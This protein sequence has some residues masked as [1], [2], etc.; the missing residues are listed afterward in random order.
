MNK[1]FKVLSD[2]AKEMGVAFSGFLFLIFATLLAVGPL[3]GIAALA[4]YTHWWLLA[5]IPY[6][7][8]L[9]ILLKPMEMIYEMN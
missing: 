8:L 3:L 1:I 9:P 5:Y 2:S 6:F 4:D 7:L